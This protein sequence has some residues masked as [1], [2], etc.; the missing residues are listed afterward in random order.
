[1]DATEQQKLSEWW[2][3][4]YNRFV[5]FADNLAKVIQEGAIVVFD[6]C[7]DETNVCIVRDGEEFETAGDSLIDVF[8]ESKILYDCRGDK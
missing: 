5:F 7:D 4:E 6:R 1:M 2:H 3:N 8:H